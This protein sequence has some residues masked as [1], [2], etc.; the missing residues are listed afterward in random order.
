MIY[1]LIDYDLQIQVGDVAENEED[2]PQ[3][4]IHDNSNKNDVAT[5]ETSDDAKK[6]ESFQLESK[7]E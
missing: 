6:T 7:V 1:K 3:G 4:D 2:K 5:S